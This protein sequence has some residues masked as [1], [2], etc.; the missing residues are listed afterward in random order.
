MA[1]TILVAASLLLAVVIRA[2]P[3]PL[4]LDRWGFSAI[5]Y[6]RASPTLVHITDLH[7]PVVLVVAALAAGLVA[8]RRDR[9]RALACV[10]GPGVVAFA[11]E[12]VVKPLAARHYEEVLSYPSGNVSDVAAVAM[13]WVLAVP[14]RLRPVV[15]VLAVIVVTAMTVAVIGLRW[16][17]PTDALGGALF[18]VGVVLLL[19]GAVH[20]GTVPTGS[21]LPPVG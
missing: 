20:L 16:H 3:A 2:H 6:S 21:S 9:R 14:G 12:L 8:F 18:G 17:Y 4:A 19:D 15:T 11:V 7:S 10:V 5:A 1:G 13:A